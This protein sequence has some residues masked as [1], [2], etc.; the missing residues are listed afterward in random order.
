M[1]GYMHTDQY[2][3]GDIVQH[4]RVRDFVSQE[5]VVGTITEI[6]EY[7]AILARFPEPFR[8]LKC[9]TCEID[10][11]RRPDQR[12]TYPP[13]LRGY[14]ERKLTEM[15]EAE[16]NAA[17]AAVRKDRHPGTV[18]LLDLFEYRHLPEHLAVISAKFE[19]LAHDL[20]IR[21]SDGPELSAGL[22]KLVE[23]KDCA[24]RQAVIDHRQA[25]PD[26]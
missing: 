10:L 1:T 24:V 7:G 22:R 14:I 6:T 18:H 16:E 13:E 15:Y 9:Q 25:T 23:A 11:I 8:V 12:P 26:E 3:I 19:V 17:R 2:Q 20:V 4:R 21:L 5:G